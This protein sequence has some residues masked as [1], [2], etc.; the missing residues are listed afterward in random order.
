MR[1]FRIFQRP[2]YFFRP[3]Q[4]WRRLRRNTIRKRDQ[5]QLAWGLPV[6]LDLTAYVGGD[7]W[8]VGVFDRIVPEAI[9]R[10]LDRGEY[11]ID[12]GANIGQNTSAMALAAGPE[13]MTVGFEPGP[14][15]WSLLT[16]NVEK[17]KD[18][19]IS[20]IT[21]VR[22]GASDRAG[23]AFLYPAN[24]L[25]G[26]SLESDPA[27][28]ARPRREGSTGVDIEVT[29]LDEFLP[30]DSEIGLIKIDVE[31]HEFQVLKGARR[32]LEQKRIRDIVFEDYF[33]QPSLVVVYLQ[34]AGYTVFRLT[35]SWLGPV[36]FE[37]REYPQRMREAPN[38]LAT[39]DPERA[40][41]RFRGRGWK[42]LSVR[43]QI[44]RAV[45]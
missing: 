1:I 36:L 11:A 45:S 16:R 22:K 6:E 8:N 7:I 40:R 4:I 12:I 25:G 29:T 34:A 13:G 14:E 33:P 27:G 41:A 35:Q 19:D 30:E 9:L 10:L 31:G 5:I 28:P 3:V 24:D 23:T 43:V 26:F 18:Y 42:C 37:R 32:L 38:F 17:W 20:P 15:S 44:K 2:E 39:R 21:L